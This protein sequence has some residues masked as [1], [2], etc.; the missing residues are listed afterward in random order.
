MGGGKQFSAHRLV[1]ATCSSYFRQLFVGRSIAANGSGCHAHPI[2][3]IPDMSDRVMEYLLAFMYT[4][5]TTVPTHLLLPL[6]EAAKML[7]IQGLT[8]PGKIEGLE[9]GRKDQNM[10]KPEMEGTVANGQ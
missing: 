2:V 3:Y 1:L 7:G 9:E 6:I 4:G 10:W 5:Q 8:E